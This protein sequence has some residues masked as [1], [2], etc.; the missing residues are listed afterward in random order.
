MKKKRVLFVCVN[1]SARSQMAEAFF[2]HLASEDYEAMSAGLEPGELNPLAVEVMK[3]VGIDISQNKTK[4]VFELY[5]R[6]ELF[7]YVIAVCDA[8]AAEKCP[9]FP[10]LLTQ[11][12]F[13]NI[14]DPASFIGTYEEKLN[15]M[16]QIRDLL[17]TK[18]ES[19]LQSLRA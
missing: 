16:R 19:F 7:A 6:G 14:E 12:I 1:N 18:V 8:Q 3:E 5:R 15:K 10:G 13:W 17:K 9:N 11:T 4:S 2:N